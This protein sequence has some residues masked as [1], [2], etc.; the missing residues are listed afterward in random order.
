MSKSFVQHVANEVK[1]PVQFT[2]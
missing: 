2:N 1:S